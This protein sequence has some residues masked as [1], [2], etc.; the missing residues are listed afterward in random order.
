[1]TFLDLLVDDADRLRTVETFT[2]GYFKV[3]VRRIF[4]KV[5][6]NVFSGLI[7]HGC[8]EDDCLHAPVFPFVPLKRYSGIYDFLTGGPIEKMP[9][10]PCPCGSD[11]YH[12]KMFRYWLSAEV[13][14]A[15]S[16]VGVEGLH[17]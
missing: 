17:I 3:C 12:I 9:W 1:M 13:Y 11:L 10:C 15:A 6:L 14:I 8:N 2:L 7:L 5:G 4:I 16:P